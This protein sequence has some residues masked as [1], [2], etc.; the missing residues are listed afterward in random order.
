[1]EERKIDRVFRWYGKI[2]LRIVPV[3]TIVLGTLIVPSCKELVMENRVN[4]PA[5][6]FVKADPVIKSPTWEQL[7]IETW[8]DGIK[9]ESA[10]ASVYELNRGFYL[11]VTKDR[12]FEAS[13]LG[14]WPKEWI[15]DGY[16]L[17]P[18]GEQCPDGVG[19]YFGLDVGTDEIY[20][21]PLTLTNLY[22]DVFIQIEGASSKYGIDIY[23][24]GAVDGYMYPG[25]GLHYGPYRSKA[26]EIDYNNRHVRIPRQL[27]FHNIAR[28]AHHTKAKTKEEQ[29]EDPYAFDEPEEALDYLV[30]E[31]W[32]ENYAQ[33]TM[34]HYL[35]VPIGK[36]AS[37][38]GYD[39][40]EDRLDDINISI[41]MAEE[42]LAS[43]TVTIMGWTVVVYEN[44]KENKYVI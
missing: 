32:I 12:Y 16:L 3:L 13:L 35:S 23:A 29:E 15:S 4:C 33:G 43:I 18:E 42:S 5:Y 19:A 6:V 17:I 25:S 40:S 39:W 14:G 8:E 34:T 22:T 30:A 37:E 9:T 28:S 31:V 2:T 20:E 24:A 41:Q 10:V 7:D 36:I 38:R 21:A 27:P 11:P 44:D 26:D 1:M